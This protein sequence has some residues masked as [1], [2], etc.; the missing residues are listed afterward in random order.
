MGHENSVFHQMQQHIPW[1]EFE[2]LVDKHKADRRLRKLSTKANFWRS[3]S[4]RSQARSACARS[5]QLGREERRAVDF[6]ANLI[7]ISTSRW[8][9][10]SAK[11]RSRQG[12]A[13]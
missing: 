6:Y 7:R 5:Q 12:F 8:S 11:S 1:A 9:L 13:T 2:R 10:D 4:L 3:C